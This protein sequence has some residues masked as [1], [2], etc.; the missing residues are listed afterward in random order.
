MDPK[1]FVAHY[2]S[3]KNP[4]H[5]LSLVARPIAHREIENAGGTP[6]IKSDSMA[7]RQKQTCACG[8]AFENRTKKNDPHFSFV[9]VLPWNVD[10]AWLRNIESFIGIRRDVFL[11]SSYIWC[12]RIRKIQNSGVI[13]LLLFEEAVRCFLSHF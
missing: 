1:T 11:F 6:K 8:K 10:H 4:N 13:L 2:P 5:F 7:S 9:C 3:S 12:F